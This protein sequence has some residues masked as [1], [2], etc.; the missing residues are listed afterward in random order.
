MAD[1]RLP[2]E[3]PQGAGKPSRINRLLVAQVA[4]SYSKETNLVLVSNQ[5]LNSEQTTALR[6]SLRS[7]GIRMRVVR[8]RITVRAFTEMGI[9][10]AAKLFSGPT[11]IIDG[12]DPVTAAKV[13][14][15]FCAKFKNK[16]QVIGGLVEGQL[17]DAKQI[18]TLSKSKSRKEMLAEISGQAKGPGGRLV[19][20]IMGPGGKLAGQIKVLVEKLEKAAPAAAP[21]QA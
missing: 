4:K 11:A 7:K 19:G 2:S 13:A 16:L 3:K 15:E 14:L 21:A 5:G 12:E 1:R 9:K 18:V 20:A 10:D 17:L 6:S 8:S